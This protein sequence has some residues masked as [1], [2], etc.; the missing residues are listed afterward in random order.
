[1][2]KHLKSLNL[3]SV[4]VA[5]AIRWKGKELGYNFNMT[6]VN[7][8]LYI[9]YG[10]VL[11]EQ[12]TKLTKE[13]PQAWA[14]GPVFPSVHKNIKLQDSINNDTYL[15]LK[16]KYKQI[17]KILDSVIENF[18]EIPYRLLANWSCSDNTPWNL[19]FKR[20]KGQ[21]NT[22]LSDQDIFNYFYSISKF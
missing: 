1:M 6:Q 16:R 11:V 15:Y 4:D 3:N 22:P 14:Y 8:L 5:K 7:K 17:A 21:W 18:G 2:L 10:V 19:A 20:S 12:K 13:T 9:L